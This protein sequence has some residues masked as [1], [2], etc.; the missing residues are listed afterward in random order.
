MPKTFVYPNLDMERG[1]SLIR[2]GT[3]LSEPYAFVSE[4][5]DDTPGLTVHRLLYKALVSGRHAVARASKADILFSFIAPY[6]PPFHQWS[7]A[8]ETAMAALRKR[9]DRSGEWTH[10]HISRFAL[11]HECELVYSGRF[12]DALVHL[13]TDNRHRHFVVAEGAPGACDIFE[14]YRGRTVPHS[15]LLLMLDPDNLSGPQP[16]R[17]LNVPYI[18]T[19]RWSNELETAGHTAPWRPHLSPR[20]H[21]A[22]FSGSTRGAPRAERIRKRVVE[23]CDAAARTEPSR[24]SSFM[25]TSIRGEGSAIERTLALKRDA[26]FCLEPPGYSPPRKSAVDSILLGCIPVFFFTRE[27]AAAYMPLF[28]SWGVNASILID[29]VAFL[30]G[31]IDLFG[32]LSAVLPDQVRQMQGTIERRAHELVYSLDGRYRGDAIETL[33]HHLS[34]LEL[35]ARPSAPDG[36][37]T[38]TYR[39][40]DQAHNGHAITLRHAHTL[41][42][43]AG[44]RPQ[45]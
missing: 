24:C 40:H 32:R 13:T 3:P 8:D 15:D 33:L 37:E 20:R 9:A 38:S 39:A 29:P 11:L 1:V 23:A 14:E 41:K 43:F 31:S 2:A 42:R 21:L 10:R 7:T 4:P 44:S 36:G 25:S 16:D 22:T 19:V 12:V 18:S 45:S 34:R 35:G 26:V 27:Q 5:T 6:R 30:E 28:F 17:Q